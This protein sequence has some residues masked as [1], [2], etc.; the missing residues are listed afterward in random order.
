MIYNNNIQFVRYENAGGITA[1]PA[2]LTSYSL[3]QPVYLP[4]SH[5]LPQVVYALLSAAH[6]WQS[7]CVPAYVSHE[8]ANNKYLHYAEQSPVPLPHTDGRNDNPDPDAAF[9]KALSLHQYSDADNVQTV[10]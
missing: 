2:F 5:N 7:Q 6:F 8:S 3:P 1:P 4:A 10:L 9:S